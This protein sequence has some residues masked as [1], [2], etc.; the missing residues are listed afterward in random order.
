MTGRAN[1]AI[2]PSLAVVVAAAAWLAVRPTVSAP[3]LS[4]GGHFLAAG[5]VDAATLLP[6]PPAADSIAGRADLE[7]V[8]QAQAWRTPAE[9]DWAKRIAGGDVFDFADVLGPWFSARNLPE[10][11]RFV[12][13]VEDDVRG[14]VGTAKGAFG[15]PR[16]P[17]VDP[18][19]RP[20]VHLPSG[21]SYPSGHASAIY[22]RAE[23]LA[24]LFPERRDALFA[25]ADRAAW[26]RVLGGVHFPTDLEAGRVL[27]RAVVAAMA[28]NAAFQAGLEGCRAEM[29][30]FMAKKAA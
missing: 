5:A 21:G 24:R 27:A 18:E 17:R 26:G 14:V 11:Q 13:L 1:R 12:E 2:V 4:A 22:A 19:I 3:T 16:P 7:A 30:P 25:W 23:V 8:R 10:T 15:R 20:C 29:A 28:G 6:A 9:V